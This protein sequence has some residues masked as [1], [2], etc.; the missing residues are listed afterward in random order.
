METW[1]REGNSDALC[2][3][4]HVACCCFSRCCIRCSWQSRTI[5]HKYSN[6]RFLCFSILFCEFSLFICCFSCNVFTDRLAYIENG[7]YRNGQK[8]DAIFCSFSWHSRIIVY[9]PHTFPDFWAIIFS[10][11][12]SIAIWAVLFFFIFFIFQEIYVKI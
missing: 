1:C 3:C 8:K 10:L 9:S 7:Q 2:C 4:Y 6:C 11:L 5:C 12:L